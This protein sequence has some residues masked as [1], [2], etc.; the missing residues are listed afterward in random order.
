MKFVA[1]VLAGFHPTVPNSRSAAT[2]NPTTITTKISFSTGDLIYLVKIGHRR[3]N[4]PMNSPT[5]A[6]TCLMIFVSPSSP[7][8]N[9]GLSFIENADHADLYVIASIAS[10]AFPE[11]ACEIACVD[12]IAAPATNAAENCTINFEIEYDL[13]CCPEIHL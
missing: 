5:N 9:P 6:K 12:I 7:S 8:K 4:P 2:P 11:T 10:L 13:E 3:I 1:S